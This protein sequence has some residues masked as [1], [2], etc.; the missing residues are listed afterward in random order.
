MV[1]E[2]KS[3]SENTLAEAMICGDKI[4]RLLERFNYGHKEI[5][6][7]VVAATVNKEAKCQKIV[8]EWLQK[9][10]QNGR[11]TFKYEVSRL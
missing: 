10:R 4:K 3:K 7:L 11:A 5:S 6:L 8:L 2:Y 9:R 1:T